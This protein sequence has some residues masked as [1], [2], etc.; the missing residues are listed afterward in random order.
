MPPVMRQK[1]YCILIECFLPKR[2]LNMTVTK[3]NILFIIAV[4]FALWFAVTGIFWTYCAA[5]F[6][7]YPFAVISFF[8]WKEIKK[9]TQKRNI[10][11]PVILIAGLVVSI[12]ALVI[13]IL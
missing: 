5:L 6:I 2:Y 4:I 13:A 7:A 10:A 1:H 11:I 3:N 9:D 8:I 12:S